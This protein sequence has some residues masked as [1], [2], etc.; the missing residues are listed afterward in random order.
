MPPPI[1]R[2]DNNR[3]VIEEV[4]NTFRFPL[5]QHHIMLFKR[6]NSTHV[7]DDGVSLTEA[8]MN[9]TNTRFEQTLGMKVD[10]KAVVDAM[11]CFVYRSSVDPA[12]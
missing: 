9:T 10:R 12:G 4:L 6:F 5:Q 8:T 7:E 2:D 11:P 1:Q 3:V